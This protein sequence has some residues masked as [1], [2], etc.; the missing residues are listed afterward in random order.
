MTLPPK[1]VAHPPPLNNDRSLSHFQ[2]IIGINATKIEKKGIHFKTDV[3]AAVAAVDAKAPYFREGLRR[4]NLL[5]S[6]PAINPAGRLEKK[7]RFHFLFF[8]VVPA[9][10]CKWI[11]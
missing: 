11:D 1:I 2:H 5:H 4:Q 7:A 10:L 3:F 9:A 6:A 8:G